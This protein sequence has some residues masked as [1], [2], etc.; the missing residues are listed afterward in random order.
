MNRLLSQIPDRLERA[1]CTPQ[2]SREERLKKTT[3]ALI[4]CMVIALAPF[5]GLI[6]F[7]LGLPLSAAIPWIYCAISGLTLGAFY[8][9]KRYRFFRASQLLLILLLPFLEQ[10]SLGG[11]HAS[12]AVCLWAVLSPLGAMMFTSAAQSLAWLGGF[13]GLLALSGWMEL[14]AAAAPAPLSREAI[15]L[16]YVMNIGAVFSICY[17]VLRFFV[18]QREVEQEKSER[19][20]LNVLPV[21]IAERLKMGETV[22]ADHYETATVLFADIVGFTKL[23]SSMDPAAL[24]ALL[25]D[26][27]SSFDRLAEKHGLEKIKTIGDAYMVAGGLPE[28][29]DGH[30]HNI[31]RMALE[32]P[33]A[34][35]RA[36][37]G[38]PVD[39]RIG[40]HTGAVVAGVI[41]MRKFSYDL[42]GDTVNTASRM[43]SHGSPG[44]V[45]ISEPSFLTLKD[46][47]ECEERG[48]V[49]VKGKGP[50]R[51]FWLKRE[52]ILNPAL[53]PQET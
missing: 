53:K 29:D 47:F 41:G 23:S 11:F 49:E 25:N 50:M 15:L 2:D 32:M 3:F 19:L 48:T 16:F 45:H 38:L 34:L 40:I 37:Q 7:L 8:L 24:V 13:L 31:A 46:A 4:S 10:W 18:R 52:R 9:T 28:A 20:L 39:V 35:A 43:E 5:W 36:A 30:S 44:E 26:I 6:Y 21:K 51:T 17:L 14:Q 12:S 27:F 1:F 22:I 33:P 42:W